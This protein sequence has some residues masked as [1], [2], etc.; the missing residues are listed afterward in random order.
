MYV[1]VCVCVCVRVCVY[2]CGVCVC[3]CVVLCVRVLWREAGERKKNDD[4]ITID[5]DLLVIQH[6]RIISPEV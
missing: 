4:S 2:V 5:I 1:C 3:V 6:F